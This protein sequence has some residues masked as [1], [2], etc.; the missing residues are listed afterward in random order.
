MHG[1]SNAS[2]SVLP[3]NT[4]N[5]MSNGPDVS[6]MRSNL[7]R[8]FQ[9]HVIK[10]MEYSEQVQAWFSLHIQARL[11]SVLGFFT[12]YNNPIRYNKMTTIC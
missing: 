7:N 1:R 6:L 12:K 5:Y 2:L 3:E 8:T 11:A 4:V 9:K 10:Y